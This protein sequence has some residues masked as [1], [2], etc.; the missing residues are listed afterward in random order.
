[1]PYLPPEAVGFND[2]PPTVPLDSPLNPDHGGDFAAAP[3]AEAT[4]KDTATT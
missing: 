1:M 2:A 4:T 3:K